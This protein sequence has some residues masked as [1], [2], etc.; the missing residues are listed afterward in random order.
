MA[1]SLSP[2]HFLYANTHHSS[3]TP[4]RTNSLFHPTATLL[5]VGTPL[6]IDTVYGFNAKK[7]YVCRLIT[8]PEPDL[9]LIVLHLFQVSFQQ[10]ANSVGNADYDEIGAA[11]E[12]LQT[13]FDIYKKDG[14]FFPL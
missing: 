4:T 12:E 6:P 13:T 5:D 10:I 2:V 9:A 8:W 3:S 11:I 14:V 1:G 7:K